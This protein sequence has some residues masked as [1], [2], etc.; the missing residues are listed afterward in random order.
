MGDTL[1]NYKTYKHN[2]PHLFLPQTKYFVTGAIYQQKPL[3][4]SDDAKNRLIESL[5][6]G[7]NSK[8][9][10]LEDWVALHNHYHVI[11]ESPE[12]SSSLAEIIR[13]VHKFTA[14]W[15][16]KY[17]EEARDMEKIWW[18]YWDSCITHE[19]SYLSR[20]N[21]L[22]YNPQKHGVIENAEDWPFGSLIE[23]LRKDDAYVRNVCLNYPCDSVKVRDA[24]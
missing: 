3:L 4:C 1:E 14:M 11:S 7:F 12:N 6:I 16:R 24:F 5:K 23:H 10:K 18:N 21:Y 17:V 9:W 15:L 19:A 22:W 8:G 20:L 13:D 2:P